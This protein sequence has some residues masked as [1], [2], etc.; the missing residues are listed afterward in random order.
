VIDVG[1]SQILRASF[2][3]APQ[4]NPKRFRLVAASIVLA[5]NPLS[6]TSLARI[7]GMSSQRISM[8]LYRLHS[9]LIV[10]DSDREQI[11]ICHKSFAGFL[12]DRERCN[13][14][15][16]HIN[17]QAHHLYLRISCLTMMNR[18]L[19]T[20]MCELPRYSINSNIED[21]PTLRRLDYHCYIHASSGSTTYCRVAE[22]ATPQ[23][24][25]LSNWSIVFFQGHLLSW[26]EVLSVGGKLLV[27]V[28]SV[29]NLRPWL[30]EVRISFGYIDSSL[31]CSL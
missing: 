14:A 9:V 7:L 26:L 16:L 2:G 31:T 3:D 1:Y 13:D 15:R 5:F 24:Q 20:N 17:A 10:P 18:A 11:R 22:L 30:A 6:R 4:G 28:Y 8:I 25:R 12:T 27:A 23:A 21:I 29:H 19:K